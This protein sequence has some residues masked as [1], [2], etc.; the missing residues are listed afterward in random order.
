M[1]QIRYISFIMVLI[2][3]MARPAHALENMIDE[4]IEMQRWTG[5]LDGMLKRRTVR[6]LIVCDDIFYFL[7]HGT[8]RGITYE[9][10]RQFETFLNKKHKR[11][12][13][14]INVVFIPAARDRLIDMLREG[15]GDIAAANLTVTRERLKMV[16]FSDPIAEN[17]DEV[18]VTGPNAPRIQSIED[19]SGRTLLVRKESSYY[20]HLQTINRILRKK[21][22]KKII[23]KP[24]ST[25]LTDS[26]MLQMVN[27]GVLPW[28]VV[29]SHKAGLW[30][31][32]L[33]DITVRND[34]VIHTGGKIAWAIRRDSPELKRSLNQFVKK[35]RQG[36]LMGNILINRYFRDS[37]WIKNPTHRKAAIRFNKSMKFFQKY[38]DEYDF[39]WLMLVALAYQESE[40]NNS[41]RSSRGA[42]GIMQV[43]PST[44][45][46]HNVN[47]KNITRLENN[48]KAGTRYLR[49][50]YQR[51]FSSL[52]TDT[53]NKMLFTFAAYNAGPK[54][55][56]QIR[57]D[58]RRMKLNPDIWFDNV[59]IAAAK[60]IGRETV[61]Y[62]GNIYK[63]YIAY[64]LILD[65]S[66]M[67]EDESSLGWSIKGLDG[68]KETA[69]KSR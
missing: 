44:A 22:E 40:L 52:D 55:I 12:A 13:L 15:Y 57:N 14:K 9:Y 35:N 69:G 61:T 34:I 21:G 68:A 54:R 37:R 50:L 23:I 19:L 20:E 38:A 17:I 42:V 11:R 65:N 56:M 24:A 43:L 66:G 28:T 25:Y 30:A 18:L 31:G 4:H 49:F 1:I 46:D 64:R 39:D 33:P 59:E 62:V 60:R 10:M 48:I 51:Y 8:Q 27:A 16:D 32:V 5:D 36:T 6:V 3:A 41:K 7:D 2:L 29:D 26:D 47:V 63:Y 45:R 58:A 67:E 53:L